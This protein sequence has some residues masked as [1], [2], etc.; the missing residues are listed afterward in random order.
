MKLLEEKLKDI[1]GGR[2]LDVA[3]GYGDFI[4]FLIDNFESYVE[5]IGI[6]MAED[7]LKEAQERPGYEI[8]YNPMHAEKLA[9]EDDYFDTVA[10]RHSM[11][12]MTDIDQVLSEMK[13]VLKENGLFILGEIFQDRKTEKPNSHRHWHHW[14]ARVDR[15]LG[16]SHN[17]TL[18]KD[19]IVNSVE[20][21]GLKEFEMFEHFEENPDSDTIKLMLANISDYLVKL[22]D[23]GGQDDLIAQGEKIQ[24]ILKALGFAPEGVL[25]ILGR[26]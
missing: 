21:L 5:A 19:E 26:K 18:T 13:R 8:L 3:T 20:K 11:H 23:L 4:R 14:R 24:N 15:L 9:F 17:E 25:Y 2:I 16:E 22:K 12:H 7:R 1:E 10:M 6:D